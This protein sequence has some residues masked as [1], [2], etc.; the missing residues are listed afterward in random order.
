VGGED[1]HQ[2]NYFPFLSR[3]GIFFCI[4]KTGMKILVIEDEPDMQQTILNFLKREHYLVE[5]AGDYQAAKEKLMIYEYDCILLDIGLPGGSGLE[6]LRELKKDEQPGAV[7]I[8]SAKDSLDDKLLGLNS[9]A[10]DYLPKPFHLAELHARIRSVLR[11]KNQDGRNTLNFNNVLV[12]T[13]DRV[14][15][16]DGAELPLNRKEYDLLLYMM[17]NKRR[18]VTKAALTEHV[19]GDH[20][21]DAENFDFIYSQIKNLRKKLKESNA[22]AEIQAI[23]GIGYKLVD[24]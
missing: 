18:L 5:V 3:I 11:R 16:V 22:H 14:I 10:D 13:K 2:I 21:E 6:L 8:V 20:A 23:Y 19:W 1:V 12:D 24:A 15:S 7:I 4:I 9:G 17:L